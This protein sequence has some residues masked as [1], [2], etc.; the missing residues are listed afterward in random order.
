MENEKIYEIQLPSASYDIYGKGLIY[1]DSET[2]SFKYYDGFGGWVSELSPIYVT[3]PTAEQ[4]TGIK[5]GE[6]IMQE[7]GDSAILKPSSIT[8]DADSFM[9]TNKNDSYRIGWDGTALGMFTDDVYINIRCAIRDPLINIEAHENDSGYRGLVQIGSYDVTLGV[10]VNE[11]MESRIIL[12][13]TGDISLEATSGVTVN[14]SNVITAA[15]FS[16]D[17]STGTLTITAN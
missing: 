16:Y 9:L 13:E 6:I 1:N 14:G 4:Q 11:E 15:N 5:P 2:I 8:V 7:Y 3:T 17:S 12:S 10:E